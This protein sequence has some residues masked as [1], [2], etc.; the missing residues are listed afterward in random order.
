MG[1]RTEGDRKGRPVPFFVSGDRA[2]RRSCA[3]NAPGTSCASD[4]LDALDIH[5]ER[6]TQVKPHLTALTS[7]AVTRIPS[8]RWITHI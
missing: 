5:S 1:G 2:P 8:Y 6:L 4:T 3:K 7:D